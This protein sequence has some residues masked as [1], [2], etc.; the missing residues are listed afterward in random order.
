MLNYDP[1][2]DAYTILGVEPEAS[3]AKIEAAYRKAARIWHPDKSPAPDAADRFHELRQAADIL[4]DKHRRAQYDRLRR[5]SLG[6]RPP[7]RPKRPKEPAPHA[8]MAPPPAWLAERVRIHFD[9]VIF[10]L[11]IPT[12]PTTQGRWMDI[13]GFSF[14]VISIA[15][16]DIKF[17][18]LA[19]VCLFIARVLSTPPHEGVL[20]WAKVIPGRRVA[21]YHALDKRADRYET[22]TIP[23]SRLGVAIIGDRGRWRIKVIG[24]PNAEAPELASTR[25]L[26]EARRFARE[27]GNWLRLPLRDVA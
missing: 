6:N 24:F 16:R 21:E 10:N 5:L 17:A 9:A 20:A 18:A 25:D 23:Y 3:P 27:A 1:N 26:S 7:P 11:K 12:L 8:S 19:L 22:W 13:L 15:A 2:Q 14:L 4:R